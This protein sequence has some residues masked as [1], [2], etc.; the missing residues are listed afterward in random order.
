M[1]L[2]DRVVYRKTGKHGKITWKYTSS[3]GT[4]SYY[5]VLLDDGTKLLNKYDSEIILEPSMKCS[6]G[7]DM[8][9]MN[10]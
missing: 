8:L 2:N 7:Y 5:D 6:R 9:E 4:F 3:R 1:E 10:R